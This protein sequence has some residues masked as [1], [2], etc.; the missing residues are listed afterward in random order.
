[1]EYGSLHRFLRDREWHFYISVAEEELGSNE[2]TYIVSI[3]YEYSTNFIFVADLEK[4]KIEN[5]QS[6]PSQIYFSFQINNLKDRTCVAERV[7]IRGWKQRGKAFLR[8]GPRERPPPY[9]FQ[10]SI[11]MIGPIVVP[12]F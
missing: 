2:I 9:F 5:R 7:P 8:G 6:Q 12:I 1:V 4:C 11:K 3:W 10:R